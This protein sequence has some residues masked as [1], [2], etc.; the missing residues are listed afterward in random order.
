MSCVHVCIVSCQRVMHE[1]FKA[2]FAGVENALE[3]K[4]NVSYRLMSELQRRNILSQSQIDDIKV[5]VT[6]QLSVFLTHILSMSQNMQID[7][8]TSNIICDTDNRH[9]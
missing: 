8:V 2:A 3:K 4:L 1:T 5:C 6:I 9:L 7:V